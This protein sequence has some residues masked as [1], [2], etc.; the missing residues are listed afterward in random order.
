MVHKFE[1]LKTL[2]FMFC[3]ARKRELRQKLAGSD[4]SDVLGEDLLSFF[5]SKSL[6]Y[7]P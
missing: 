3:S 6:T 2:A 5:D 1:N 7:F 4:A